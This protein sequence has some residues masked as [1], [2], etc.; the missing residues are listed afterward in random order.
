MAMAQLRWK[1][2]GWVGKERKL[3]GLEGRD[4]RPPGVLPLTLSVTLLPRL[5]VTA[6]PGG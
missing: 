4:P 1:Q 2:V 3:W 5:P 6:P